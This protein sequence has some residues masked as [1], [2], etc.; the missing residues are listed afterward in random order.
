MAIFQQLTCPP[1]PKVLCYLLQE[2]VW[3]CQADVDSTLSLPTHAA[4]AEG[5]RGTP[6]RELCFELRCHLVGRATWGKRSCSHKSLRTALQRESRA[7]CTVMAGPLCG[8]GILGP[9]RPS[10]AARI[11]G[12]GIHP[13]GTGEG[14][15]GGVARTLGRVTSPIV[16]EK[17]IFRQLMKQTIGRVGAKPALPIHLC[18]LRG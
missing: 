3:G 4:P 18:H 10:R 13:R 2:K 7:I 15:L 6:L 12:V 1:S 11:H 16:S 9:F 17:A 8:M 5:R 14:D